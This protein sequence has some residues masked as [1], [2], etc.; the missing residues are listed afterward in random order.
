MGRARPLTAQEL[1]QAVRAARARVRD[2]RHSGPM[3]TTPPRYREEICIW[4]EHKKHTKKQWISEPRD[5]DHLV[6]Q[7]LKSS[8]ANKTGRAYENNRAGDGAFAR[9]CRQRRPT[10]PV[11]HDVEQEMGKNQRPT[12]PQSGRCAYVDIVARGTS[13]RKEAGDV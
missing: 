12:G 13:E 11:F 1:Q 5:H 2:G 4:Q 7:H 9:H 6:P 8:L 10:K 3:P